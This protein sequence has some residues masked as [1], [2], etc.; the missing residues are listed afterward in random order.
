MQINM[1]EFKERIA[2]GYAFKGHAVTAGVAMKDGKPVEGLQVKIPL[3]TLNRHGLIAGATGTGKTKTLQ[4]LAERF[5]A[6]GVPCLMMDIKG[7]LSG[8]A[9]A[10]TSSEKIVQRHAIIHDP[11][12]PQAFPVEFL[13][14][15]QAPGVRMRATVT[16]Y[17]PVLFS[18]I[19]EL[20]ETQQ[21]I[22]SLVFKYCDDH[23]LPLLD[24]KDFRKALQWL[25][26]EGRKEVE[27]TYGRISSAS[28]ST[29]LRK[30]IEIEEQGAD[31]FFGEPSFDVED[32]LKLDDRGR[33]ILH[34]VRLMDMQARPKLF[35]TF[36][37]CL[38]AEIFQRFPEEGDSEQ[39]KLVLFIDE[40]HLLFREASKSLLNQIETIIK[41][42]RSKGVGI[43]FVTQSPNDIPNE[44]LGQLGLKVQ[45]ALR[46][47]TAADRKSIKSA[48]E[49]F[50]ET[51][52]FD[53]ATTLTSMGIGEALVTALNEKGIPTPLVH[54]M[55]CAPSSRMDVLTDAELSTILA[56]SK[57]AEVYNREIDRES[58]FELLQ[59]RM[60]QTIGTA[61][62][63]EQKAPQS[64]PSN[65]SPA[66]ATNRTPASTGNTQKP[67]FETI[68]SNP[69]TKK[70][71][72]SLTKEITRG[73]LGVFG[74]G[75]R[76][77]R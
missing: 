3:K 12:K 42:I 67:V 46:A 48:S 59:N 20:N 44:I 6:A 26:N 53:I 19:L 60:H 65:G 71:V 8:I 11:W 10:G 75:G 7:D 18:R 72:D 50:P 64:T 2:A 16:E 29:I 68:A 1:D 23:G 37:L 35:S 15:S 21:G 33:G 24:L 43:F 52:D 63:K 39:P 56:S 4:V 27:R 25:T 51:P 41:L 22:V 77:R 14:I 45:H 40:A 28:T 13:T 73:L 17:G 31:L 49:N 30:I 58:A 76:K 5:S 34:V 32:L 54:C 55:L 61:P 69:A 36:M 70:F 62:G 47:F 38:L 74:L 66:E 9:A 57:L